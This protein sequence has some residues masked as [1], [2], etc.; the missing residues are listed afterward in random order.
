MNNSIRGAKLLSVLA[1]LF[2]SLLVAV[3]S[4]TSDRAEQWRIR[5]AIVVKQN[6][7][8]TRDRT[9]PTTDVKLD[10]QPGQVYEAESLPV[11]S[12]AKGVSATAAWGE[13][14]LLELLTMQPNTSYPGQKLAEELFIGNAA[15]RQSA[16]GVHRGCE[17]APLRLV[18][19]EQAEAAREKR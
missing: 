13:G 17:G 1:I 11:I 3:E 9:I 12:L 5:N 15:A 18:R 4:S 8:K 7:L 6:Q 10:L 19:R 16:K 14:A 2:T